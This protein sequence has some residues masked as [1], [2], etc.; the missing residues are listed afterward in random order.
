MKLR[1]ARANEVPLR[2]NEDA[3]APLMKLRAARANEVP[4]RGNEVAA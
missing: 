1:A 2:G 3:V 4:L